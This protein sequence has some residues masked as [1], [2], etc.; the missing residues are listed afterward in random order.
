M[1]LIDNDEMLVARTVVNWT[2]VSKRK[3][4]AGDF[5]DGG[6]IELSIIL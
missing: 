3:V 1:L 6:L 5:E 4:R 2:G